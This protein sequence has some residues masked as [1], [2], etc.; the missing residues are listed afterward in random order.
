MLHVQRS[1]EAE[2]AQLSQLRQQGARGQGVGREVADGE[3]ER[4]QSRTPC[5]AVDEG[6]EGTRAE[7]AARCA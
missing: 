3:V 6:F 5:E 1:G 2:A 7:T 4:L